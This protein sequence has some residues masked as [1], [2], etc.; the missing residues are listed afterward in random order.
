MEVASEE[1]FDAVEQAIDSERLQ[2]VIHWLFSSDR[3]ALNSATNK[4]TVLESKLEQM[5][6]PPLNDELRELLRLIYWE[7]NSLAETARILGD[8]ESRVKRRRNKTLDQL[9]RY[10]SDHDIFP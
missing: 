4:R 6:K 9:R 2:A 10:F 8:T 1:P 3:E 7:G 5:P